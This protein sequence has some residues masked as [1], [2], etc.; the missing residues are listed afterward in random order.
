MKMNSSIDSENDS[1]KEVLFC[2]LQYEKCPCSWY[3][4]LPVLHVLFGR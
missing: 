4:T 3:G 2:S 1:D